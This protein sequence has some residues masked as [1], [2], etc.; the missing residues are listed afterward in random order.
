MVGLFQKILITCPIQILQNPRLLT[1]KRNIKDLKRI[2]LLSGEH[3]DLWTLVKHHTF[4][5]A[6]HTSYLKNKSN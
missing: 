3:N 6:I 4:E 2:A 5:E 1:P